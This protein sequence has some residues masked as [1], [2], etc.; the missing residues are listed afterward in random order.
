MGIIPQEFTRMIQIPISLVIFF[1][2]PSLGVPALNSALG[3]LFPNL[4]SNLPFQP[5]TNGLPLPLQQLLGGNAASAGQLPP[6]LQAI[7]ANFQAAQQGTA[8]GRSDLTS[9]SLDLPAVE[10][11]ES[12]SDYIK[13][14]TG[15]YGS[16]YGYNSGYNSYPY[17]SG[18][19][20]PYNYNPYYP[21]G[22]PY[23]GAGTPTGVIVQPGTPTTGTVV[24]PTNPIVIQPI[25][26]E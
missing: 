17:N 21:Y 4:P 15:S 9:A 13:R 23:S 25:R 8:A 10:D 16:Y 3:N 7:I 20:Y 18:Y 1:V 19:G 12:L 11:G 2:A 26:T 14:C 6:I 22:Y 5:P 24:N